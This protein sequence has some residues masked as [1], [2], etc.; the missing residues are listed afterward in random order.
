MEDLEENKEVF[1]RQIFN[2]AFKLETNNSAKVN[3]DIK[4]EIDCWP[5]VVDSMLKN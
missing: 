5:G 1:V 3:P 2:A 4:H